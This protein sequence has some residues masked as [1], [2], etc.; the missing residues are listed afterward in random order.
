MLSLAVSLLLSLLTHNFIFFGF[1]PLVLVPFAGW[2][3]RPTDYGQR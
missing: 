2:R 1:L 3:R